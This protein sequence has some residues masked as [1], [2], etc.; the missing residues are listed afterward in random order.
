MLFFEYTC[1]SLRCHSIRL[2]V[3]ILIRLLESVQQMTHEKI[4]R[5]VGC[6]DCVP[7]MGY[8]RAEDKVRLDD[9]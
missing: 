1:R 6:K 9:N 2:F 3:T 8:N 4:P 7:K 5:Q